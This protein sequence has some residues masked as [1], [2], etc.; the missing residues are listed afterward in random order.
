M[1]A[2]KSFKPFFHLSVDDVLEGLIAAS[3]GRTPLGDDPM[4]GTLDALHE[5]FG[6]R[7]DLYVFCEGTRNNIRRQLDDLSPALA[8]DLRARPWLRLGPHALDMDTPPHVQSPADL[9][10]TLR[11]SFDI[12]ERLVG[13]DRMS[14]WVRLHHFSE[15]HEAAPLLRSRGVDTLLTTDKPAV[16]YRL[17]QAA[18][19][20]LR[21]TGQVRHNGMNFARSHLRVERLSAEGADSGQLTRLV[22]E[23]VDA[24]GFVT[25]FTHEVCFAEA[26]TREV[27][28]S[29]IEICSE[30]GL[31]SA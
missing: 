6:V 11:R 31:A 5:A 8:S 3:D 22:T 23:A 14:R 24:H 2:P 15:C 18:R 1:T 7:A 4:L 17:P 29:V 30:L 19:A 26:G 21:T 16:A 13:C 9:E 10:F 28:R 20:L 12:I 25:I 27:L